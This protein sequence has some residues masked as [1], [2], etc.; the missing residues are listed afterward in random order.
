MKHVEMSKNGMYSFL[1]VKNISIA[2]HLLQWFNISLSLWTFSRD[3]K[4]KH[5]VLCMSQIML[6]SPNQY[7]DT[8]Y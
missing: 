7:L 5:D 4:L 3:V 8:D 1:F 6:Y 2:V